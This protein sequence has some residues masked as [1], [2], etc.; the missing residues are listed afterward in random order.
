MRYLLDTN[1][2]RE[3]G[4]GTPHVNVGRWLSDADDCGLAATA[5]VH[6]LTMV[7]RN[8]ADFAGR[9]VGL[10]NPYKLPA[11]RF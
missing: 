11:E 7:T 10:L 5:R 4:K 6:G 1:V 2:F 3:I 8:V 9:A